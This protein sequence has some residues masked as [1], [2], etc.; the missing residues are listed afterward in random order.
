MQPAQI[1][2]TE[3]LRAPHFAPL[4]R[5]SAVPTRR[6]I[7]I[8]PATP[9]SRHA[10]N[11]LLNERYGWRGYGDVSLPQ[12]ESITHFPLTATHEG[13]VIGTLTVGVDGPSG[14]N[15]DRA[16]AAEVDALRRAGAKLCEFTKLAIDGSLGGKHVL[17]ALFHV[18]YLAADRLAN[19]DTLL[20]EV[21]PRHVRYYCRMLG[22]TV[23]GEERT[24]EAVNAPAVLLSMAFAAV[25][26]KIDAIAGSPNTVGGERSLYSLAFNRDEED[27]IVSRLI[28]RAPLHDDGA[29]FGFRLPRAQMA[30]GAEH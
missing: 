18:A 3:A 29:P 7:S 25:R 11:R 21:N 15:C 20:M 22:A 19:V 24:N 1:A 2:A 13:V 16:F 17:A 28:R 26:G 30:V 8:A 6:N 14:L 27:A 12:P 9:A 4:D 23:I 5:P 10:A